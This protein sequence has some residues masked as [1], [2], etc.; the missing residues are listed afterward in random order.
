MNA[1][2]YTMTRNERGIAII[3]V[4][5]SP[6]WDGLIQAGYACATRAYAKEFFEY[7]PGIDVQEHENVIVIHENLSKILNAREVQA[8]LLH[9]EGHIVHGHIDTQYE[10]LQRGEASEGVILNE[11]WEKQADA[12]AAE[13]IDPLIM[14]SALV[15][16]NATTAKYAAALYAACGVVTR[17]KIKEARDFMYRVMTPRLDALTALSR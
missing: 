3:T 7:L 2:I 13:R 14:R 1:D 4:K 8:V 9:E 15:K 12:Y 10:A 11:E 16:L 17:E 5:S 6:T